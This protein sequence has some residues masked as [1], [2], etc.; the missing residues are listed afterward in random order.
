MQQLL[1]IS[2]SIDAISRAVGKSAAWLVLA[3]CVVA[4][5]SAI[6]SKLFGSGPR[7]NAWTEIQWLMFSAVFL[8]AAPWTLIENEHIRID[9]LNH[10]LKKRTRDWIDIAGHALFLLPMSALVLWT[11]IPFAMTS[12]AQNEG[13]SNFGG[14]PQWP[15]KML[16]PLAFALLFAQG[17]SEL[18]KRIAIL[19]GLLPD[20]TNEPPVDVRTKTPHD[21]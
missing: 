11:S 17:V 3:V 6:S 19:R 1:A 4:A 5:G 14:L 15:L 16:I 13:S 2:R 21:I 7:A 18:I 8:F 9:I 12:Y 10:R 20:P